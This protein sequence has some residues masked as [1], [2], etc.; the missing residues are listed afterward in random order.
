MIIENLPKQVFLIFEKVRRLLPISHCKIKRTT[1]A[2]I[3]NI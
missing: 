2:N 3:A 1:K